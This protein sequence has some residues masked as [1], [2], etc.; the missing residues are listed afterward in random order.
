MGR[1]RG[2]S[3]AKRAANTFKVFNL[4]RLRSCLS[5]PHRLRMD[6]DSENDVIIKPEPLASSRKANMSRAKQA[7]QAQ[8]ASASEE[9]DE[10]EVV[11]P[12]GKKRARTGDKPPADED[13]EGDAEL[14]AKELIRDSK[15]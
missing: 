3:R 2:G 7:Q 13:E 14:N 9:E 8:V 12:K 15:G 10:E 6:S 4:S 1:A 5:P 11:N